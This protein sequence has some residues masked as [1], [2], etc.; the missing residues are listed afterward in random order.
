MSQR[1]PILCCRQFGTCGSVTQTR[2]YTVS[3][4]KHRH[5]VITGGSRGIGLAI[6]RLLASHSFRVTLI[7]RSAKSLENAK[8]TLPTPHPGLAHAIIAGDVSKPE[9]WAA[10][11]DPKTT[12]L[13]GKVD[14][15][16]NCAG[17]AQ[18]SL[19]IRTRPLFL[20]EVLKT[21]LG[22]VMLGVR[23]LVKTKRLR[24]E[25]GDSWDPVIINLASLLA[26]KGGRGAVAYS[27]SKAGMLGMSTSA[28][29]N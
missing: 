1:L 5:A 9:F 29:E 2:F 13:E 20:D 3:A 28:P 23:A 17:I 25:E 22:A 19:L 7:S 18:N 15:L 12:S 10:H 6:A 14:V 11:T 16:I 21:N 8:V 4:F 27:T 26:L 24:R